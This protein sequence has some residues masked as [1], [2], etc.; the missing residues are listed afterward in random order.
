MMR[1]RSLLGILGEQCGP[2]DPKVL[3]PLMRVE[4]ILRNEKR[5]EDCREQNAAREIG[6][7]IWTL[8]SKGFEFFN[9]SRDLSCG[10]KKKTEDYR[11]QT[12]ARDSK[13]SN[14]GLLI[15]LV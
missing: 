13:G 2:Y 7:M 1:S 12:V 8:R 6:R 14:Q 3:I 11:E 15:K 4:M 5:T 10:T 9:A